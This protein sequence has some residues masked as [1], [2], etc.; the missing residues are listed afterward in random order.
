[1]KPIM[2]FSRP[3]TTDIPRLFTHAVVAMYV[4]SDFLEIKNSLDTELKPYRT[5]C[6]VDDDSQANRLQLIVIAKLMGFDGVELDEQLSRGTLS[7]EDL[8]ELKATS[9]LPIGVTST[10]DP[11]MDFLRN[12]AKPDFICIECYNEL[13]DLEYLQLMA[14]PIPVY[15][16][17]NIADP[18]NVSSTPEVL[19]AWSN[20]IWRK[21]DGIWFWG[22]RTGNPIFDARA[23]QNYPVI[24][25]VVEGLYAPNPLFVFGVSAML[26]LFGLL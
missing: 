14:K 2:L 18:S 21:L 8:N 6:A 11:I 23:Q 1:M 9:S 3:D 25:Q 15:G 4:F 19:K 24:K 7:I 26:M 5:I 16:V 10:F 20:V 13:P 17:I 22:W 12:G